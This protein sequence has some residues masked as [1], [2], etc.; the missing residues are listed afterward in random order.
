MQMN[1]HHIETSCSCQWNIYAH[2]EEEEKSAKILQIRILIWMSKINA[3]LSKP[4]PLE[5]GSVL[6][7]ICRCFAR[8]WCWVLPPYAVWC[9]D[10]GCVCVSI[11]F[12]QKIE[13]SVHQFSLCNLDVRL[14]NYIICITIYNVLQIFCYRVNMLGGLCVCSCMTGSL[15]ETV[16]HW[17]S[18]SMYW[19]CCRLCQ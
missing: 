8:D 19:C 5:W 16:G 14:S 17:W 18:L 3:Y 13:R 6:G 2:T 10:L 12:S 15:G 4:K 1:I 9:T 7:V 11:R